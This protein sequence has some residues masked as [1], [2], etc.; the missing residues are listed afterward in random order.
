PDGGTP[1]PM[2]DLLARFQREFGP[3]TR[4]TAVPGDTSGLTVLADDRAALVVNHRATARTVRV[5][6]T[7]LRLE[8]YEVRWVERG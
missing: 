8:A 5:D 1:L 7:R 2:L 4:F 6:G 3:G